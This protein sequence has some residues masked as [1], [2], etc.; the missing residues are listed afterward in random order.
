MID[1]LSTLVDVTGASLLAV[2]IG[3][4]TINSI[5]EYLPIDSINSWLAPVATV[6]GIVFLIYKI[7]SIRL[8]VK[9][10][11]KELNE[12]HE[13]REQERIL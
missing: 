9:I 5:A 11:R 12:G 2:G 3:T 4:Y 7:I 13:R 6:L 1:G 10:K 8:D